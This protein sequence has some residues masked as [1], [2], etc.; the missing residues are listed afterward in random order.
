MGTVYKRTCLHE[1]C[2][3]ICAERY[4]KDGS[5]NGPLSPRLGTWRGVR[6]PGTSKDSRSALC[7]RSVSPYGSSARGTCRDGSFTG[8]SECYV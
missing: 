7:Q 1:K 8:N 5:G 4:V 6:L 2:L 3:I